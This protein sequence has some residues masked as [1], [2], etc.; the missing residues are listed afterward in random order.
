[1]AL[2]RYGGE[3]VYTA[4]GGA[5]CPKNSAATKSRP[6]QL[7]GTEG[8]LR[9]GAPQRTVIMMSPLPNNFK[10]NHRTVTPPVAHVYYCT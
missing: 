5:S 2:S 8:P 3:W 6:D 10:L 9:L 4:V 1:M 7:K